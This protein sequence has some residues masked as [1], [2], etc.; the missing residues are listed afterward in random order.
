MTHQRCRVSPSQ[1]ISGGVNHR[2]S[3]HVIHQK[4]TILIN[5]CIINLQRVHW[6]MF[7]SAQSTSVRSEG[8]RASPQLVW[9]AEVWLKKATPKNSHMSSIKS[10][11]K[12][13]TPKIDKQPC[14]CHLLLPEKHVAGTD[15]KPDGTFPLLRDKVLNNI[16][17]IHCESGQLAN[18]RVQ[19]SLLPYWAEYKHTSAV[20]TLRSLS[21][22]FTD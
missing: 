8:S 13:T 17:P 9:I 3:K 16:K 6:S 14:K 2:V 11:L 5:C 18:N 15:A 20:L 1:M 7:L 19:S 10:D 21:P 4:A 22:F 12:W